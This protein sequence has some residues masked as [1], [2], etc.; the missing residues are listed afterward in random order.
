MNDSQ[1]AIDHFQRLER[2]AAALAD[3]GIAIY[4]HQYYMLAFGGFRLELGT[5]HRRWGFSWDGKEG[6]LTVSDP[7]APSAGRP[8]P[9]VSGKTEHLG[10]GDLDAPFRFIES[11]EFVA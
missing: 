5:R 9:P 4:E 11:F 1:S 7:Y 6:F 3:H 8:A 10:L 2:L